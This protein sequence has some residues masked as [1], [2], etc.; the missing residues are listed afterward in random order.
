MNSIWNKNLEY[1]SQR[2]NPLKEIYQTQISAISKASQDDI[3]NLFSFWDIST[4]KNGSL[5]AS[6]NSLRLHSSYNPEKEAFNA[7]SQLNLKNKDSIV[8]MGMGLGYHLCEMAK[9]LINSNQN[10]KIIIIENEPMHFF[11]SMYYLDWSPIFQIENLILAIGCPADSI[12]SLLED[13]SVINTGKTG[14]SSSYFFTIPAF[15]AHDQ[16]YFNTVKEL[17]E[18]N[19]TK[20]DINSA[21]YSKFAK[22]WTKN[23]LTNINQL[24]NKRTVKQLINDS[25]KI[26]APFILVGAGPSLEKLLPILQ[27]IQSKAVI[28]CVETALRALLRFKIQPDFIVITDP[29]YYAYRHIADLQSPESIL[30]CPLSVYPAVF[31]FN[32]KEIIICSDFF[33]ISEFFEKETDSFG[34]LGAGGSVAS[35]AWNLCYYLGANEVYLAGLD[36]SYPSKETHIRGSR[37]EQTFHLNSGKIKTVEKLSINSMYSGIPEYGVDYT[38]KKVLTDSKMKMFAW[39]FESRFSKCMEVKNYS[40]SNTSLKIPGVEYKEFDSKKEIQKDFSIK[41]PINNSKEID[42][43]FDDYKKEISNLINLINLACERCL[44]NSSELKHELLEIENKISQNKLNSIIN[45][46]KPSEKYMEENVTEPVE[47]AYFSKI[48]K[49]L[50]LYCPQ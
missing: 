41:S 13:S 30:I 39:W 50:S 29:Q 22:L 7:I 49:D 12:M 36:L 47:L 25:Q 11:A 48:Q 46:S 24:K 9:Y 8:F 19:K 37:A 20:N 26:D 14:V 44:I 21:T 40:L 32:C 45:L 23:S 3:K 17:I 10:K 6:E 15:T 1:F 35:S 34:D 4:A 28:V 16:T 42:K 27:E 5:T 18:R 38:G 2:F 33:P 31:R 43:I